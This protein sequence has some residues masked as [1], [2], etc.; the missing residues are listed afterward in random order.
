MSL[1]T[2][3]DTGNKFLNLKSLGGG[4]FSNHKEG[5]AIALFAVLL[6][7]VFSFEFFYVDYLRQKY[8]CRNS[9]DSPY[10]GN[11]TL[12]NPWLTG[13][14]IL[15]ASK[16]RQI[17]IHGFPVDLY[18]AKN[19]GISHWITDSISFYWIALLS[20]PFPDFQIA[21]SF[22][23]YFMVALWFLCLYL[24]FR[25]TF[26]SANQKIPAAVLILGALLPI[27]LSDTLINPFTSRGVLSLF[28]IGNLTKWTIAFGED[29]KGVLY[30]MR[31]ISPVVTSFFLFLWL[32]GLALY[33]SKSSRHRP[34]SNLAMGFLGSCLALVHFFD[35]T[36][37]MATLGMLWILSLFRKEL[38]A[39]RKPLS[40]ILAAAY[41]FSIF[42]LV[43]VRS[44]TDQ[45]TVLR[46][47]LIAERIFDKGSP[48]LL[49]IAFLCVRRGLAAPQKPA[50][51]LW[52]LLG[53][54]MLAGFFLVNSS[55]ISGF[56]LQ[57]FLYYRAVGLSIGLMLSA[58][59]IEI[60]PQK[61]EWR[62][63]AV[64]ASILLLVVTFF[65]A[66]SFAELRYDSCALPKSWEQALR[67]TDENVEKD[68]RMLT[69]SCVISRLL[70]CWT[71]TKP[72]VADGFPIC[73]KISSKDNIQNLTVLLKTLR[74]SPDTFLRHYMEP[75][76]GQVTRWTLKNIVSVPEV[77]HAGW[78]SIMVH[79]DQSLSAVLDEKII[80]S[81]ADAKTLTGPYYV[82][83]NKEEK[84]WWDIPIE[85]AE[86]YRLLFRNE[87]VEIY[88][89]E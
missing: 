77:Y 78:R 36:Y 1:E 3:D 42:F 74:I 69:L 89:H 61:P 87:T 79:M 53:S 8:D 26:C 32:G 72:M 7:A 43:I 65:N 15:Y 71:K 40:W 34:V 86:E 76:P 33:L 29:K 75:D 58:W 52:A 41:L 49:L 47:G 48:L 80:E 9:P 66:K 85:A 6:F 46:A 12:L 20:L 2:P 57:N 63:H 84:K 23:G 83:I 54:S 56:F 22:I 16:V 68:S 18:N 25:K 5:C 24:F 64:W 21:W 17:L 13:D 82:W 11:T 88:R 62:L 28:N 27:C 55:V 4:I 67:W 60:L 70:P 19:T 50:Q 31:M 45:S 44:S 38:A 59:G 14:Q 30:A 10:N 35:W 73:S 39:C 51:I 81:M 37:G